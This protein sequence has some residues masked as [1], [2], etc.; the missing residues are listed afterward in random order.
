MTIH[1]PKLPLYH[2]TRQM[3]VICS[4][5]PVLTEDLCVVQKET[6]SIM[7]YICEMYT[8]RK[9][10]HIHLLV[11]ED[12]TQGLW[13]NFRSWV[14]RG[15]TKANWLAVHCQSKINFD[16]DFMNSVEF[17]CEALASGQWHDYNSWKISIVK[18]SYQ[19]TTSES[20]LRRLSLYSSD[21]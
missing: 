4:A 20:K 14:S 15:L 19:E 3:G 11:R 21:L 6:L 1:V 13:K 7:C 17:S 9:A 5:K 18:I 10:K 2:K 12:V 8:W 16:F